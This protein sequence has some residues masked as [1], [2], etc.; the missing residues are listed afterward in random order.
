MFNWLKDKTYFFKRSNRL[1]SELKY[2]RE[3]YAESISQL[4]KQLVDNRTE[5][6]S[7]KNK[8]ETLQ[9]NITKYKLQNKD[10]LKLL[11]EFDNSKITKLE[12]IKSLRRCIK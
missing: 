3:T 8:I 5:N 1:S 6:D 4:G 7:L 10:I 12:F 11:N 9:I 2:A